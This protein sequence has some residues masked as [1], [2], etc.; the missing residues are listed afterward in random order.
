MSEENENVALA[1]S[2]TEAFQRGDAETFLASLHPEV[3]VFSDPDLANAGTFAGRE[4][5]IEWSSAWFEVWDEFEVEVQDY[6]PV[7]ERHVLIAV[8]QRGKGKGSGVPV[9]MRAWY[10]AEY[11]D[12]LGIRFHLYGS[13]E[14]ALEAAR[15]GESGAS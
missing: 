15:A 8:I 5:W 1:K 9:E 11:E 7:G 10:M 4:G 3:E 6:E 13:R 12:R 14:R 2:A